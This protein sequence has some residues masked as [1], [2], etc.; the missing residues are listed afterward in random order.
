MIDSKRDSQDDG[1]FE[2][3]ARSLF[4]TLRAFEREARHLLETAG[5]DPAFIAAAIA[6]G[7][8][9]AIGRLGSLFG[10][11]GTKGEQ[12]GGNLRRQMDE[13]LTELARL[14]RVDQSLAAR[15][16]RLESA[17][18]GLDASLVALEL[19]VRRGRSTTRRLDE[20]I[21]DL[22]NRFGGENRPLTGAPPVKRPKSQ[23]PG[24]RRVRTMETSAETAASR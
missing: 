9:M 12:R 3:S 8:E 13:V 6:G 4:E 7:G 23:K 5:F 15:M 19:A 11:F 22:E 2:K 21:A 14:R 24:P 18:A 10:A 17:G 16:E 1:G 20:R